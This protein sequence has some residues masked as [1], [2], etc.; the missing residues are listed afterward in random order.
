QRHGRVRPS[1]DCY[2][3]EGR[4]AAGDCDARSRRLR[5]RVRY[6]ASNYAAL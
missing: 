6:L 1:R 3:R 2:D 5:P 4:G